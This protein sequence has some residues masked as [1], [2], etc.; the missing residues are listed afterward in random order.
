RILSAG[1]I[2]PMRCSGCCTP[3]QRMICPHQKIISAFAGE[4]ISA[5]WRRWW[6]GGYN[7][8]RHG[9]ARIDPVA[10]AAGLAGGGGG[11]DAGDAVH[12]G[13]GRAAVYL[14]RAARA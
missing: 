9:I 12:G 7:R 8:Q 11:A 3:P 1:I 4:S 10:L 14:A 2:P 13:C 5:C 6:R